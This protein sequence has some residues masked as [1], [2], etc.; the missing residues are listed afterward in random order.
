[1]ER[2]SWVPREHKAQWGQIQGE[3]RAPHFLPRAG[4]RRDADGR[5][6][7]LRSGTLLF[8]HTQWAK[9]APQRLPLLQHSP[10]IP[11]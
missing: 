2:L 11:Q 7:F 4:T 10:F 5:G 8:T 9:R 6:A 3:S 1:M